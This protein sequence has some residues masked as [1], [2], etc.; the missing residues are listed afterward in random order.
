VMA[1]GRIVELGTHEELCAEGGVYAT[2][3]GFYEQLLPDNRR[4]NQSS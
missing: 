3:Y 2:L 1:E 4:P